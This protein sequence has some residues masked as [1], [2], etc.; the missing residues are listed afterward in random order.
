MSCSEYAVQTGAIDSVF[1][2]AIALVTF[3]GLCIHIVIYMHHSEI[4]WC[5]SSLWIVEDGWEFLPSK[6]MG[7]ISL[8]KTD[9]RRSLQNSIPMFF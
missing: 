2:Q 6:C 7:L 4:L 8:V 5:F 3:Y 1:V 9:L